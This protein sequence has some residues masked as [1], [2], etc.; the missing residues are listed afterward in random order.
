[1]EGSR[2]RVRYRS[3]YWFRLSEKRKEDSMQ[4][5][6]LPATTR[7]S[8]AAAIAFACRRTMANGPPRPIPGP[9]ATH[10]SDP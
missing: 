1:M 4:R 6:K 8:P 3:F 9:D 10:S 2:L 5:V 7:P